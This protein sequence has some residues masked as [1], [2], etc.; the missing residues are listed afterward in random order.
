MAVAVAALLT[1]L[2][3]TAQ[4][5]DDKRPAK[6]IQDNS[7]LIEEAYNQEPGVVQ[8]ITNAQK[9]GRDWF[10]SFTQEV[11][12][13]SQD[14]QVSYTLPYS[15]LRSNWRNPSGFGDAMINYRYQAQYETDLLPAIAP[16]FSLILPT[17]NQF[18]GLGEGSHGFDTNFAL[19]KIVS[20]QVTLHANVGW[21]TLLNVNGRRP[22]SPSIG[23]SAV[24]AVTR[25]F[26]LLF[27]AVAESHAQV[28]ENSRITRDNTLTLSPG[29]RYALN[30][31]NL[32]DLQ[33]VM[34]AAAPITLSKQRPDYGAF[35]YLSFEHKLKK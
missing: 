2:G 31:P 27:E 28:D 4:E 32:A 17:G 19:S 8:H 22:T 14:H 34:G 23:A 25:D 26:N 29:F 11:P 13:G 10:L 15:L 18:K 30:F 7:F 35:L 24:Y 12:L 9:Q 33:V 16:R 6:G 5:D 1:C 20:D 21:Q 3:A